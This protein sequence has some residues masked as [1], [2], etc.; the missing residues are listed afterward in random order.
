VAE[1]RR[2][3]SPVIRRAPPQV[4]IGTAGH[5]DHGKSSL[6]RALT[7]TD[8][9]RL[10]EEKLRGMTIEL[11]FAFLPGDS[12]DL[13]FIDCPGHERFIAQMVAGAGSI[14]GCLLVIA[15]DEGPREQ[16]REHLDILK[17]LG[18]RW[19][20]VVLS[21]ADTVDADT[22]AATSRAASELVAG[23]PLAEHP[24]LAVSV[25]SGVGLDE[26]KAWLF[27]QARATQ[28]QTQGEHVRLPID[29]VF[30]LAGH[31][32]VVTG[33]LLS[34]TIAIGETLELYPG[35]LARVRSLQ[36]NRVAVDQA[37]AGQRTAVNLAGIE[38]DAVARGAWLA[39][40][41]T[42]RETTLAD[43]RFEVL[44]IGLKHRQRIE[45]HHGTTTVAAQ[46][47]LLHADVVGAGVHDA[48]VRLATP[49]YLRTG[50]RLVARRPSPSANLAGGMVVDAAP[51]RHRRFAPATTAHFSEALGSDR[52]LAHLDAL[53]P[54]PGSE[55]DIIAWAGGPG[56]AA[57][58]F[59]AAGSRL[60]R[61]IVGQKT[62]LWTDV[63]W[64]EAGEKL[65]AALTLKLSAQPERCWWEAAALPLSIWPT[66]PSAVGDDVIAAMVDA[67]TLLRRGNLMTAPQVIPPFP[68]SLLAD[69]RRLLALY[70]AA[71]LQP[72]YD[73]PACATLTDSKRG[74]R[75][76]T[77]LRERGWLL[78]LNDRQHFY[79]QAGAALITEIVDAFAGGDNPS[80]NVDL[81][82]WLKERHNLTRKYSFPLC[83]W[84]DANLVTKRVGD[85]RVLGNQRTLPIP[86]LGERLVACRPL[87]KV[88]VIYKSS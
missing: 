2:S 58:L 30:T 74:E 45:L 73:F 85:L 52:L 10:P 36:V 72:P 47:N 3:P 42:L 25:R 23:S 33:T 48:Q 7:G 87:R 20:R 29:R 59:S 31:G 68:A 76:L 66:M 27:T 38:R 81:L 8:P 37:S 79:R 50:D 64:R 56:P 44:P 17:L 53:R 18:I 40:P 12:C 54:L 60:V 75:A 1:V 49:L 63:G 19:G 15:A 71:G 69:A 24:P 34:G 51:S 78:Q 26:L 39:T 67:G 4:V 46:V 16:S 82:H 43:V 83:D 14:D 32:T 11:G 84:L 55:S 28:R 65:F 21:K 88:W 77:A 9:D 70:R 61:R 35:G 62:W 80:T 57:A 22:L 6:V 41:G 86:A 13:A 5:V